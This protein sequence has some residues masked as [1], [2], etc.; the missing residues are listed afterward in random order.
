MCIELFGSPEFRYSDIIFCIHTTFWINYICG[1]NVIL[2]IN[3]I[4]LDMLNAN[5]GEFETLELHLY[6]CKFGHKV[7]S[8]ALVANLIT[9]WRHLLWLQTWSLG[10]ATCIM[11]HH[12]HY[13]RIWPLSG[14]TYISCHVAQFCPFGFI[15]WYWVGIFINQDHINKVNKKSVSDGRTPRPI[16]GSDKYLQVSRTSVPIDI[17]DP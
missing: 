7:V 8:F 11:W 3:V 15:S 5:L 6:S 16:P 4:F 14:A 17:I 10:G 2:W 13:L 1:I 12:L 9:R